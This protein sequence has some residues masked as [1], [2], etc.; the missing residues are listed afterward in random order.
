MNQL[1]LAIVES[2]AMRRSGLRGSGLGAGDFGTAL[3]GIA[4][5]MAAGVA[6]VVVLSVG[7]GVYT[8][9]WKIGLGTATVLGVAMGGFAYAHRGGQAVSQ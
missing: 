9:S 7:A 2:H 6:G 5:A 8:H 1:E 4:I 3:E